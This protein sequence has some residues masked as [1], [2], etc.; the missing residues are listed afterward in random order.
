MGNM[1]AQSQIL[2]DGSFQAKLCLFT[3]NN[4]E[5]NTYRLDSH[6]ENVSIPADGWS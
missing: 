1:T 2:W 3:L 4:L 6:I 5:R